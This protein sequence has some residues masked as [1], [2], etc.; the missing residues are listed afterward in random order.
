MVDMNRFELMGD[1]VFDHDTGLEWEAD[2]SGP[3][4][5][6]KAMKYAEKLGEGWRL[7]TIEELVTLVDYNRTD[8]AS[9]FPEMPTY[10]FWSS[11]SVAGSAS[12]AWYVH[13]SRHGHVN[14]YVKTDANYVRCVRGGSK[15][16]AE[17]REQERHSRAM[18]EPGHVERIR[19]AVAFEALK[20]WLPKM[21]S[22]DYT[23]Q[24][25]LCWELAEEFIAWI[26]TDDA[27]EPDDLLEAQQDRNYMHAE[28]DDALAEVERLEAEVKRLKEEAA[29]KP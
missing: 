14:N 23:R 6:H 19:C 12:D 2:A 13:F 4:T 24:I 18:R 28:R 26:N 9:S 7:P 5:W 8:P 27:L 3:M 25:E 15:D 29:A 22:A 10:F 1:S 20:A 21:T 11:S 17:Q 16:A